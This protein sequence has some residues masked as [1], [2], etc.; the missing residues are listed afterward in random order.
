M[1]TSLSRAFGQGCLLGALSLMTIACSGGDGAGGT[2]GGDVL[3][4]GPVPLSDGQSGDPDANAIDTSLLPNWCQEQP[5]SFGFFVT[6]MDAL[7]ALSESTPGDLNG[8]FGGNFGGMSGADEICQKIGAATGNGGK[9]WK[10][11]LSATDDGSGN[12]V[13]AIDRIG[14]GPWSDANGRLVATGVPGLLSSFRPD[15]DPQAVADLVDECGVP[16]SV[17]GDA[18]DVVT[19]SGDDG[20]LFRPNGQVSV[21]ATCNDWTSSDGSVG[22][23]GGVFN[24]P[25]KCGHSFPREG[26]GGG[27]FG[28][29]W[30]SDHSLRGCGK[31]ANLLQNGAGEG[32]CIGCSGGYGALY[33]FADESAN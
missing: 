23:Q 21:Q 27:G 8:G 17:L 11:F 18:H 7:W 2:D 31:G 22:S 20:R 5:A 32:T 13:D 19:A 15:G 1:S 26:S 14:V 24:G 9:R 10:A 33:C 30:L 6:S 29:R 25:L 4:D 12:Q 3:S 28:S 16:T